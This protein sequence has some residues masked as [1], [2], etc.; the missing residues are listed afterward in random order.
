MI[1][2]IL[3]GRKWL[4]TSFS[5][6]IAAFSF[7]QCDFEPSP[8]V[9]KLLE[10]ADDSKKYD[11][12]QRYEFLQSALEEEDNCLPC[13]M[14]LGE[15]AFKRA[16][17]GNSSFSEAQHLYEILVEKCDDYHSE[18]F[19]YLGAMSY[20]DRN[21]D[22]AIAYFDRFLHFPDD[23]PSKFNKDYDKLYEE[24]TEALPDIQF[25]QEFYSSELDEEPTLVKGV[26]SS[27]DEY[28]P[29]LSPDGEIM[30]YT[31]VVERK[32]KG[33]LYSTK[34]EEFT[35]SFR[36]DI[37]AIFDGGEPLTAPFNK[38]ANYGGAT[39][40]VDNKEMYITVKNPLPSN[41]DNFD[42]FR[43]EYTMVYDEVQ[44]KDVYQWTELERL[45]EQINTDDGWEGQPSLS[46]D[47]QLLFFVKAGPT[48]LPNEAG[49]ANTQDLFYSERQADGSWGTAKNMGPQF[50]TS[51]EE[52]SPFMHSDSH[53]LYFSSSGL[54]G[55]GGLDIFYCKYQEDG[56]WTT[57]KNIGHPINTPQ[58]ETGLV[59]S[60][61]GEMAYFY[62][63]HIK[64]SRGYDIYSFPMPNK[65]KPEKV[66]IL[67]GTVEDE[68]GE[69]AQDA[70]VE[71]TYAQS[72]TI[73]QVSVNNDDGKYATIVNLEKGEDVVM[74]VV[75]ED[76][77][78]NARMVVSKEEETPPAVV[79]LE[80]ET[81]TMVA[82][83]PFVINDIYYATSS[84]DISRESKIVLDQFALYLADHP[85]IVI[86]IRGHTDDIGSEADNL[87]LSM[88]RAFEVKGYLEQ[89]GVPGKRITA[90]GFGESKPV[91]A[92]DTADG[93]AKNRRT[94]FLIKKM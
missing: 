34:A 72:K 38:G 18:P 74:S 91:A 85:S 27:F 26:S 89:Q 5:I 77:A 40:S 82:N 49:T 1:H 52:K 16:K 36:P 79:K 10:K 51:G 15:I 14:R 31:R 44:K 83:K 60:A 24:V 55:C 61:D 20:A 7:A 81:Q 86:E 93:R 56:T 58:D 53:T 43:T 48:T 11:F 50:N 70:L 29:A 21:Y 80:V 76:I 45:G 94:E 33:D 3:K 28:L 90:V 63:K 32:A 67:K 6:C 23:D 12:D 69:P 68:H 30:F 66:M 64:G 9:I 75:H 22:Q 13:M 8:K 37:N 17:R 92:N 73:Q 47:G 78:F 35:W 88:D 19:Y 4:T 59:V 42:I 25:W 2:T 54:R 39:I 84:A 46:G 71:L 65:A 41:K 87:A 62:A 57:P